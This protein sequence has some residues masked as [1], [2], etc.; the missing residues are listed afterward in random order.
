[1]PVGVTVGVDVSV[2]VGVGEGVEL[3]EGVWLGEGEGLGVFVGD[4]VMVLVGVG[5]SVSTGVEEG[6]PGIEILFT[7]AERTGRLSKSSQPSSEISIA[8]G[9]PSNP[10]SVNPV[11]SQSPGLMAQ[12]DLA[13]SVPRGATRSSTLPVEK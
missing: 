10:V 13:P 1:V 5:V 11:T 2:A 9:V 6:S 8:T 3:G 4:G 12:T 7:K